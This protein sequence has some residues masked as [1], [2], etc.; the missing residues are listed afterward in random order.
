MAKIRVLIVDDS[1]L[2]RQV[3]T[4]LLS[5]DPEI[6][7]VG[8]AA[9]PYIARE[10]IKAL[11]PDVLTLDVEMPRMDGLT[12]LEKLM[13]GHPM[14]VVMVSSLTEAGCQTTLRALELGAVDFVT[15][16]KID[17][18]DGLEAQA[19][20]LA[21][22]VKAAAQVHVRSRGPAVSSRDVAGTRVTLTAMIKTTDTI[23]AIGAST[24]GTEAIRELLEVLPPH[25]PPIIITQHMPEKFT[26]AFADR[27]DKLCQITVKEAED[28]DSV[29][30]GQAL[31]APGN[32]HMT[33]QRSGARYC[34][35][36]NQ[37]PPVNRH[38]PSV[39]VM[40]HSVA[41][42][43]GGNSVGV[44]LTGMGRDGAAALLEMKQAGAY[45]IAQDESS[46][47]VFGMPNEAIKLGGVDKILPLA[48]IP[49]SVLAHVRTQ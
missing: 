36:L 32:F 12:F 3:L 21:A 28:G 1:A 47:V 11:N 49:S 33:L 30:T 13:A 40:F 42:Y 38:R 5:Q 37:D 34:V 23:I 25:T 6:E 48:Q 46:C 43:A 10:K 16:P 22:K 4:E 39:D 45:T 20:E 35:R 15:K 24:G 8:A 44:I 9:D 19:Q 26:K 29:L 7:V 17:L 31:I 14:P 2:M 18:R 41:Q 27:L